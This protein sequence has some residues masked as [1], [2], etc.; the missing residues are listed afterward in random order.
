ML[1]ALTN[2]KLLSSALRRINSSKK[3]KKN[4][5]KQKLK[6]LS[7]RPKRLLPTK[8]VAKISQKKE[9]KSQL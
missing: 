5:K 4:A 8:K 7:A 3:R 2:V 9:R 1:S 6:K